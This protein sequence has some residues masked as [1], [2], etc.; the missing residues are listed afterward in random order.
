MQINEKTPR[1]H[2]CK[3]HIYEKHNILEDYLFII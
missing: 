3:S 1:K 2:V